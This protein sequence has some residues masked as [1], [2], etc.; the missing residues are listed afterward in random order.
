MRM[1]SPPRSSAWR[2]FPNLS[3]SLVDK[4]RGARICLRRFGIMEEDLGIDFASNDTPALITSLLELCSVCSE[5][6]LPAGVFRE[7]P[8]GKRLECL[9]RLAAGW[10]TSAFS[11]P[12]LCAG[13]G[14]E[15]ELELTLEEI[16]ELQRQADATDTIGIELRG[17]FAVLRKPNGRDQENWA[18]MRFQDDQEATAAMIGTL[19]ITPMGPEPLTADELRRIDEAMDEADPLV[20]FLCRVTCGEC[21]HPNE[22]PIDLCETALG[23][24]RRAQQQLLTTVHQLASHY[25]WNEKEVF[26]VPPWRRIEYLDLIAAGSPA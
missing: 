7:F 5:G 15:L 3:P 4:L 1:R 9:L 26:A 11:F 24:L 22:F 12:F 2:P 16:A 17:Q 23:L 6:I 18:R 21:G 25:H 20:N 14:R 19:A 10:D 13:C 8:L